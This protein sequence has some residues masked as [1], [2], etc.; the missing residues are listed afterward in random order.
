MKLLFDQSLSFKLCEHLADIFPNSSHV[1]LVGLETADDRTL[2][3]F[4]RTNGYTIVSLDADF[5]EMA[6]LLGHPPKIIWLRQRNQPT[7][8]V[9]MLLRSH[10]P[11]INA[12]NLADAACLEIY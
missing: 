9:E 10:A 8:A 7:S 11:A 5:A 1:R 6:M 3:R 12:F 4:A 2:W